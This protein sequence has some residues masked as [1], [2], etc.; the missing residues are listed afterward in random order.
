MTRFFSLFGVGVLLS[1]PIASPAQIGMRAGIRAGT[2]FSGYS[3]ETSATSTRGGSG[4]ILGVIVEKN[5]LGP[6]DM[7]LE[8]LYTQREI[9]GSAG[10]ESSGDSIS[11]LSKLEYVQFPLTLKVTGPVAGFK[12]YAFAGPNLGVRVNPDGATAGGTFE[13][14]DFGLDVGGG[15][16]YPVLPL[17]S[18]MLDLR[19]TYGITDVFNYYVGDGQGTLK[20]RDVKLLGGVIFG[21]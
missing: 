2:N 20:S 7:Q 21:F 5:L 10:S 3:S 8:L 13:N 16:E 14:I 9:T 19:Y 11:W 1:L 6:L 17:I 18:L 4:L 12:A 15:L